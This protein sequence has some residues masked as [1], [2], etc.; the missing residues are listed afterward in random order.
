MQKNRSASWYLYAAQSERE[1]LF[2]PVIV[3]LFGLAMALA[4]YLVFPE[5][6][7]EERLAKAQKADSLTIAYLNSWLA[8]KPDEDALRLVL[9]RQNI[10]L[11][12]DDIAREALQPLLQ[13]HDPHLQNEVRWLQLDM[14]ERE[15]YALPALSPERLAAMEKVRIELRALTKLDQTLERR[16]LLAKKALALN[17]MPLAAQLYRQLAIANPNGSAEFFIQTADIL[18]STGDYRA[19]AEMYF[20]ARQKTAA[21]ER[22]RSLFLKA[23]SILRS[24]N[25]LTDALKQAELQIGNLSEDNQTLTYLAQLARAAN[26]LDLAE[27]Y[28]KRLLRMSWWQQLLQW[29]QLADTKPDYEEDVPQLVLAAYQAGL[30]ETTDSNINTNTAPG[31]VLKPDAYGIGMPFNDASYTLAYEIFLAN[32]NLND[33]MR[34]AESAIAQVPQLLAWHERL[35]LVAQWNTRPDIALQEWL[36]IAKTSNNEKAWAQVLSI[37]PGMFDYEAWLAG[38]QH[39]WSHSHD[40]ALLNDIVSLYEKLGQPDSAIAF[41]SSQINL[42]GIRK[43]ALSAQQLSILKMLAALAERSGRQDMTIAAYTALLQFPDEQLDYAGR[44]ARIHLINNR[45]AE[46]WQVL[47]SVRNN[48]LHRQ[49][50]LPLAQQQAYWHFYLELAG[51]TH[52]DKE[53]GFAYQQLLALEQ[54]NDFDLQNLAEYYR[55]NQAD[56]QSALV[57]EYLARRHPSENSYRR[58]FAQYLGLHDWH[59]I[60]RMLQLLTEPTHAALLDQLNQNPDFLAQRAFYQ[61]SI[62][63]LDGAL[64]DYR[65]ALIIKPDALDN[66]AALLWLLL[67][68]HDRPAIEQML[69]DLREPAEQN[70]VLWPAFSAA[71]MQLGRPAQALIYFRKQ[72][73]SNQHDYLWQLGFAECLDANGMSDAAWQLR[74]QVWTGW[75]R[76]SGLLLR[77]QQLTSKTQAGLKPEQRHEQALR[78][79]GLAQQFAPG[80]D[81]R[82]LLTQLVYQDREQQRYQWQDFSKNDLALDNPF[83]DETLSGK[84]LLKQL[85]KIAAQDSVRRDNGRSRNVRNPASYASIDHQLH[86]L[87]AKV[88]PGMAWQADQTD[89]LNPASNRVSAV[90][91]ELKLAYLLS[92]E[93]YDAAHAWLLANYAQSLSQPSWARLSLAL[94]EE[95]HQSMQNLMDTLEDWLPAADQVEAA[96]K[97]GNHQ[98]AETLAFNQLNQTP[99]HDDVHRRVVET[100]LA[101]PEETKQI[102]LSHVQTNQYPLHLLTTRVDATL[103]GY[104]LRYGQFRLGVFASDTTQSSDAP[105]L[106]TNLPRHDQTVGLTARLKH[107]LGRTHLTLFER[108]AVASHSG[109]KLDHEV[110]PALLLDDRLSANFSLGRNLLANE[111]GNLRVTGMKD[112][113]EMNLAWR[114]SRYETI[115]IQPS[116]QRYFSQDRQYLGSGQLINL[117]ASSRARLEYPDLTARLDATYARFNANGSVSNLLLPIVPGSTTISPNLFVPRGY[118]QFGLSLSSGDNLNQDYTRALRPFA[119]AGISHNNVTGKGYNLRAGLATSIVGTDH[120]AI[121]MSKSSATPGNPDGFREFGAQYRWYF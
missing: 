35:A 24:G 74:R 49:D 111:S 101:T 69:I 8:A 46:A 120:L 91:K 94:A 82:S 109:L 1:R 26:Q 40:T 45:P 105:S 31:K 9:A 14:A 30:N 63:L 100:L 71:H 114:V 48:A 119:S 28:A 53:T 60:A 108:K 121:F 55:A 65:H 85:K 90:V 41:L 19:A 50:Q 96:K 72:A 61:Q 106:L 112:Q 102:N 33:A 57:N 67:A 95:D 107:A 78:L 84:G 51:L 16:E 68:K 116:W 21:Y 70:S 3:I 23:L 118:T 27:R 104:G 38:L 79:A 52:H 22:Q 42:G 17:D 62:G 87:P 54:F 13:T 47:A 44:I 34:V 92:N 117:E 39:K 36:H 97:L 56:Q 81:S 4:L 93:A 98:Q 29:L 43:Q 75:R 11:G 113:F 58:A 12:Y 32:R 2:T 66:Q 5:K 59:A 64:N 110:T 103:P 20:K 7:L 89:E 18:L 73:P 37:A 86:K 115:S 76:Q 6:R 99:E 77:N 25:L 80:D 10:Q 88:L 15:A 83:V